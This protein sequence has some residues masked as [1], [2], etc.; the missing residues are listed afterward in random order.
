M[1]NKD[2]LIQ[3]IN[4]FYKETGNVPKKRDFKAS[5]GY[6]S[7]WAI[8]HYFGSWN[9]GITQAKLPITTKQKANNTW[10]RENIIEKIQ[11]FYNNNKKLPDCS[12]ENFPSLS[13][14]KR[15]FSSLNDA[16]TQAGFPK[17]VWDKASIIT[18]IKNFYETH[19]RVPTSKDF[20][21]DCYMYPS[22]HVINKHFNSWNNA[23]IASGF[24]IT[25]YNGYGINTK[26]KDGH[27]YRSRAEAYFADTYLHGKFI[28]TI[29]PKYPNLN[30]LYDWY[31]PE[32]NLYIELDGNLRPDTIKTKKI[33]NEKLQRVCIII[34]TQDIHKTTYI[35]SLFKEVRYK[36]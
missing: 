20:R 27:A 30:L 10:S 23:I 5:N 31:L 28:Y 22:S 1:Y 26:G 29:E 7:C 25:K 9:S 4:R 21:L 6:P 34:D 33:I 8:E 2:F 3:E 24:E 17:K 15:Y 13:T 32:L 14:I 19:N 11:S 16:Y 36:K 35:N 12:S 18:C